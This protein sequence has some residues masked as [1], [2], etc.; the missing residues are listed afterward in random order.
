VDGL[1]VC[2]KGYIFF[3][4]Y[5][6]NAVWVLNPKNGR[7]VLIAQNSLNPDAEAKKAGAL[8]RCSE[9]CLRGGKL[10]VSNIDLESFQDSPHTISVID[11]KDIDF[12][13]LLK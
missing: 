5:V 10:Y 12:D 8:D 3:A 6:G 13:E 4:D 9:V 7:L 1:K 2:P 11:L